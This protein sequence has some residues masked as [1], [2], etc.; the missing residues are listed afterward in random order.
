MRF[1]PRLWRAAEVSRGPIT[2]LSLILDGVC[3]FGEPMH[4]HRTVVMSEA[5]GFTGIEIED[6]LI[7][8]RAHHHVGHK[9]LT[10]MRQMV[11]KIEEAMA[12]RRG[13]G[14]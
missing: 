2:N 9:H 1:G 10:P 13:P 11:Q 6:Q 5:A 12:A 8:R 14:F 7:P 4:L 3:G